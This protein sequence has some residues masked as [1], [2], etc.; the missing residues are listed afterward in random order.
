M[1]N[2]LYFIFNPEGF[3]VPHDKN[4][5]LMKYCKIKTYENKKAFFNVRPYIEGLE[6]VSQLKP[7]INLENV[8]KTG[9]ALNRKVRGLGNILLF[10]LIINE[11][12][13]IKSLSDQI[14]LLTYNKMNE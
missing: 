5:V 8:L 1:A 6:V 13:K 12:F 11:S 3:A 2:Y 14:S 10:S 9:K 4:I 7:L